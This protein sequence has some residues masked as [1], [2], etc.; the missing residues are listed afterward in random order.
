MCL[1]QFWS[2]IDKLPTYIDNSSYI[3]YVNVMNSHLHTFQSYN[4]VKEICGVALF[5]LSSD[6]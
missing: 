3:T 1:I 5:S 2:Y 4:V 6:V